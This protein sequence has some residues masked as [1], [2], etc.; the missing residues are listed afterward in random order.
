MKK[1]LV[2]ILVVLGLAFSTTHAED[3][4]ILFIG[5]SQ[6]RGGQWTEAFGEPVI[7]RAKG[8]LF[9]GAIKYFPNWIK[10]PTAPE[11]VLI[12][13]GTNDLYYGAKVERML[14]N[15]EGLI[16]RVKFLYPDA[17]VIVNTLFPPVAGYG[18]QFNRIIQFNEGLYD[19]AQRMNIEYADSFAILANEKGFIYPE[20]SA[21]AHLSPTGY[22]LWYELLDNIL[23]EE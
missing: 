5:D 10:I 6:V 4:R 7:K 11:V 2:L 23:Y 22:A 20:Y 3:S 13:L 12:M 16:D 18:F 9:L 1:L 21:G 15:Y 19:L 8:G 17:R 14:L